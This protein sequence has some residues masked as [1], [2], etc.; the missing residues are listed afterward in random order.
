MQNNVTLTENIKSIGIIG[1]GSAGYFSALYLKKKFPE[2]DVTLV[3][4]SSIPIIGVGEATTPLIMRFLHKTLG[5]S[6]QE[7]FQKT[8]PTLKLGVKF[9]FGTK[10]NSSFN[11]PFGKIDLLP[12]MFHHKNI[13]NSNI[14]SMLMTANKAPFIKINNKI[15]PIKLDK[16]FAYHIDNAL[17]V[18]FLKEKLAESGCNYIDTTIKNAVVTDENIGIEKLI[19][20]DDQTLKYDLYVDCSGFTSLLLG[21]S[22]NSKWIDFSSSLKTNRAI[23]GSR[24]NEN[25]VRPYTTASTLN[26]GWLWNTPT[27]EVDHLGYV[28]AQEFCSDDEAFSELKK[29]CNTINNEKVISFKTGRYEN[30][31][32]GNTI[33][34]GNSFAFIEPLES[35]GIHMIILQLSNLQRVI[36]Q[37]KEIST[38]K[39]NFNSIVNSNW[40]NL[41]YFI[42]IH[43]KFNHKLETPFWKECQNNIDVNEIQDYIDYFKKNGPIY[44]DLTNPITN[45]LNHDQTFKA[46]SYDAILTGLGINQTYYNDTSKFS[47]HNTTILNNQFKLNQYIVNQAITHK[48]ALEYIENEKCDFIEN[49]FEKIL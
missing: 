38:A 34:I 14:S 20:S 31:W 24:N 6:T 35:T 19:T 11:F 47:T 9:E 12:S 29:H 26:H 2:I 22:L 33:A 1:G 44:G 42:A 49:W 32:L 48:E 5:Y 10:E 17:L 39:L 40:D 43:F 30:P 13:N 21:K 45:K 28:F 36:S 18:K 3:E 23:V 37:N 15:T 8:K 4:S 41:K 46:F 16:G 25:D 7:F 27:Q